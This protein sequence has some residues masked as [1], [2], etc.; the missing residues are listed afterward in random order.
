MKR[1]YQEAEVLRELFSNSFSALYCYT[2]QSLE[3]KMDMLEAFVI[4]QC[5][6]MLQGLI[7]SKVGLQPFLNSHHGTECTDRSLTVY[8]DG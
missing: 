4:M 1:S 8:F 7:P 2:V 3:C 6:N 5:I